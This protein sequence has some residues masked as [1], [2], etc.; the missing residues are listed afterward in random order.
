MHEGRFRLNITENFFTERLFK[1]G[2]TLPRAVVE[3]QSLEAFK[4]CVGV[5]Q[6]AI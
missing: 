4:R 1:H 5:S 6:F 3:S 2:N